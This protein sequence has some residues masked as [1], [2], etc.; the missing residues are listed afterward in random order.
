MTFLFTFILIVFI[1]SLCELN[2]Q[3]WGEVQERQLEVVYPLIV[4]DSTILREPGRL[5]GELPRPDHVKLTVAG[6]ARTVALG[7]RGSPEL[8][9]EVPYPGVLGRDEEGEEGEED[10]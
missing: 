1:P 10:Y 6:V 8:G 9:D 7:A 2:I 5:E 3:G 4:L